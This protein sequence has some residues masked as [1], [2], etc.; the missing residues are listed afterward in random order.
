M[1]ERWGGGGE[2][3]GRVHPVCLLNTIAGFL[4]VLRFPPV[5]VILIK[6]DAY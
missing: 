5:V 2:G 3:G 6:N 1:I 4:R